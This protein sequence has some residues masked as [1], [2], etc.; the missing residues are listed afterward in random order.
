VTVLFDTTFVQVTIF[1]LDLKISLKKTA[2]E[3]QFHSNLD[4]W[5]IERKKITI[6]TAEVN[7]LLCGVHQA[8]C[9]WYPETIVLTN[10][11]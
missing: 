9:K 7:N 2:P 3:C 11:Y 8:A 6:Q 5:L 4:S 1:C 10:S